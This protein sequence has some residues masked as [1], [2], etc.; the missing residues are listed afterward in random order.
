MSTTTLTSKSCCKCGAD[1][2]GMRRM[3]DSDGNYW[4]MPCGKR[5]QARKAMSTGSVCASCSQAVDPQRITMVKGLPY[6][7]FCVARRGKK[8]GGAKGSLGFSFSFP[9]L[10]LGGLFSE[11]GG[12]GDGSKKRL[13]LMIGL[14]ALLALVSALINF[15]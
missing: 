6:C 12:H 2:K 11:N 10:N 13:Y 9:S 14:I 4:C 15:R 8:G 1:L 7:N 5:D 3:K